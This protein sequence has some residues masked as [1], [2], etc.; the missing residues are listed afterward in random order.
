MNNS[1]NNNDA[2][3]GKRT[4]QTEFDVIQI[5]FKPSSFLQSFD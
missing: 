4:D 2:M 1:S 3:H 5:L